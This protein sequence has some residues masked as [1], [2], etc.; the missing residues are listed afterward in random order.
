MRPTQKPFSIVV[1][2][3]CFSNSISTFLDADL[4]YYAPKLC[5]ELN[6]NMAHT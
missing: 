3:S 2:C 4:L 1:C 6:A 5:F